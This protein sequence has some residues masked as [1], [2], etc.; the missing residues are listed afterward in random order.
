MK[1]R[2]DIPMELRLHNQ[3]VFRVNKQLTSSEEGTSWETV[4]STD[5]ISG[6]TYLVDLKPGQYEKVLEATNGQFITSS[7]FIITQDAKYI[8]QGGKMFSIAWDGTLL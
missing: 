2:I 3:G 7:M 1:V 5:T 8:D 4:S 6:G